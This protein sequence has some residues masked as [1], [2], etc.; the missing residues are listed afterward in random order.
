[1]TRFL[2]AIACVSLCL[3]VSASTEDGYGTTMSGRR[4]SV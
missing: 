2:A 4:S 3:V 1:M